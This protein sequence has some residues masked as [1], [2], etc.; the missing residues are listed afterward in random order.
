MKRKFKRTAAMIMAAV[1]TVCGA[2]VIPQP[3]AVE[4]AGTVAWETV[5]PSVLS[6]MTNFDRDVSLTWKVDYQLN[7]DAGVKE[8]TNYAKFTLAEKCVVRIHQ[9]SE[10]EDAFATKKEF[11]LYGNESMGTALVT[12]GIDYGSG[13]DWLVLDAG[14][15]YMTCKSEL[16]MSGQS[17]HTIKIS[18]GAVPA[19]KAVTFVQ[20]PSANKDK[21]TVSIQQHLSSAVTEYQYQAGNVDTSAKWNWGTLTHEEG[22]TTLQSTADP[23]FVADKNGWYT[24]RVLIESTVA[25]NQ[26]LTFCAQVNVTGID[27]KKPVIS[28]VK[29]KK[30]YKKAVTIKFSDGTGGSGIAS[31]KLNKK[32][33]KTGKK[34]TKDG[35]Y[36]LVV[37]DKAGNSNTVKFTVDKTKPT[38]NIKKNKTYKAGT[39]ITFKDKTSGIKKATL[40]G[41]KIKSGTKAKKKGTNTLKIT[42]KA[43]NVKTIKFKVK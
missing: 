19:A 25:F 7:G 28:G 23:K 10:N 9:S 5:S 6:D 26:D 29:N 30:A 16:Y 31:A 11:A 1:L 43:G 42:D 36:T 12:N 18:I 40:N 15:Y 8:Q 41:K 33:V 35:V 17:N 14:T 21:V 4:A 32:S 27:T 39:K 22:V 38:T 13:D 37:T 3:E 24:V 20:T 34:I 2:A